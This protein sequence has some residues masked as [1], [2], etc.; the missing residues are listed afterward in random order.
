MFYAVFGCHKKSTPFGVLFAVSKIHYLVYSK[1]LILISINR[2]CTLQHQIAVRKVRLDMIADFFFQ[3]PEY[4]RL[5]PLRIMVP[6]SVQFI[7]REMINSIQCYSRYMEFAQIALDVRSA[8][9]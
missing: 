3:R 6:I 5:S 9:L 7:H 8:Q 2:A 4:S 1:L